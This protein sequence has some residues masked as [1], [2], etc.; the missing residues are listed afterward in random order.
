MYVMASHKH[1]ILSS[2][3]IFSPKG[4]L[5]PLPHSKVSSLV[6][7]PPHKGRSLRF[8][9]PLCLTWRRRRK[10]LDEHTARRTSCQEKPDAFIKS[11]AAGFLSSIS[12]MSLNGQAG[13]E[14]MFFLY[15]MSCCSFVRGYENTRT[16]HAVLTCGNDPLMS[17]LQQLDGV[18][19][20]SDDVAL[21]TW[22]SARLLEDTGRIEFQ[23]NATGWGNW[24]N[25]VIG[26][27]CLLRS[28]SDLSFQKQQGSSWLMSF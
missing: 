23:D 9:P 5:L 7:Y 13:C 22:W 25:I 26:T 14:R 3:I 11:L 10:K 4:R 2:R 18:C 21:I 16:L 8:V 17:L 24:M 6:V 19:A 12:R 27:T 1:I 20:I 28:A 15:R